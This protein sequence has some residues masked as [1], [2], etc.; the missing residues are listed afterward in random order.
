MPLIKIF[1]KKDWAIASKVFEVYLD[2]QKIG[3]LAN[4]ET[5]DFEVPVGQHKLKVKMGRAGSHDFDY[6]IY[7]K[8]TKTFTVSRDKIMTAIIITGL[9]IV[10]SVQLFTN[11]IFVHDYL[12]KFLCSIT[13]LG[14]LVLYVQTLGRNK[15]LK[16]KEETRDITNRL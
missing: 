10:F 8:E 3:Y 14:I 5:N 9:L 7:N 15:L 11:K 12:I 6:T 16:I 2:G 4:G 1:R 13:P